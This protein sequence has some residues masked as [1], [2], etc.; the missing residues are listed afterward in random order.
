MT[1]ALTASLAFALLMALGAGCASNPTP[2]PASDAGGGL[3]DSSP[4]SNDQGD[5]AT[6]PDG[7]TSDLAL[8]P[9]NDAAAD[10][11]ADIAADADADADAGPPPDGDS[12]AE[13]PGCL[14]PDMPC[15]C[16]LDVA[17]EPVCDPGGWACPLGFDP[18]QGADCTR[19]CGPCHF[20]PECA[21]HGD[22]DAGA[23]PD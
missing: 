1:R 4:A 6:T 14:A 7:T 23:G 8:P 3:G 15:C 10:S 17:A 12:D 2:H 11:T 19:D 9:D 22:A 21:F 5:V 13:L 20:T 16:A 18:F